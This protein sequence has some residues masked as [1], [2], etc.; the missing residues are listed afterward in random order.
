MKKKILIITDSDYWAYNNIAD[1]LIKFNNSE[2]FYLEKIHMRDN[3]KK[4][5]DKIKFEKFDLIFPMAF[6]IFNNQ[7]SLLKKIL[8]KKFNKFKSIDYSSC[9]TGINTR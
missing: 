3:Q 9:V 4:V 1:N 7:N 6:Q 2:N 5:F 8:N